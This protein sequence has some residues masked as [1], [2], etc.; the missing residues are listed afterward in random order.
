M[1][2]GSS[3]SNEYDPKPIAAAPGWSTVKCRHTGILLAQLDNDAQQKFG[4][5]LGRVNLSW[6]TDTIHVLIKNPIFMLK[7]AIPMAALHA[8]NPE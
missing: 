1:S 3:P 6:S 4:H 7:I 5:V 8:I 2:D